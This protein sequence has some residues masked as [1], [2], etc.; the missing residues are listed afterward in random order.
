MND[1]RI[2]DQ[3]Q[4]ESLD[5]WLERGLSA[6]FDR[7]DGRAVPRQRSSVHEPPLPESIG[8]FEVGSVL[9]RGGTGVV[10]NVRDPELDRELAIKV[11]R[12]AYDAEPSLAGRFLTEARICARLQHPGIVPVHEIGALEDGR[13]WFAMRR[14]DGDTLADR[15]SESTDVLERLRLLDVFLQVCDTVAFAHARGVVHRDLKPS[16]VMLGEFGEVLVVDWGFAVDPDA[17][18]A[19]P[20]IIGTPS[21]MPPEQARG[22][23]VDSRADVFAL[24]AVLCEILTGEPPYVAETQSELLLSASRVWLSDAHHRLVGTGVDEALPKLARR[25]LSEDPDDRPSNAGE[26]ADAIREYLRASEQ[27]IRAREVQLAEERERLA[28]ERRARKLITGGSALIVIAVVTAFVAW[29][30]ARRESVARERDQEREVSSAIERAGVA[31]ARAEASG[32]DPVLWEA[33]RDAGSWLGGLLHGREVDDGLRRRAGELLR[34]VDE[35]FARASRDRRVTARLFE[36]RTHVGDHRSVGSRRAEYRAAFEAYGVDVG[37]GPIEDAAAIVNASAIR[38]GLLGALDEW[39]RLAA[40]ERAVE[41]AAGLA[42]LARLVDDDPWRNEVRLAESRLDRKSISD[43]ADRAELGELSAESLTL[44]AGALQNLGETGRAIDVYRRAHLAAPGD[45]WLNHDIGA[46]LRRRDPEAAARHFAMAVAAFPGDAHLLVDLAQML[47]VQGDERR[48]DDYLKRALALRPDDAAAWFYTATIQFR[49]G[50]LEE[51][52]VGIERT[53]AADPRF[54]A[55]YVRKA[56]LR[57]QKKDFEGALAILMDGH[58]RC[59]D[60]AEI[61]KHIGGVHEALGDQWLASHWLERSLEVNPRDPVAWLGLGNACMATLRERRAIVA[62]EAA[63]RLRPSY[64]EARCGLGNAYVLTGRIADGL[65]QLERGDREGRAAGPWRWPSRAWVQEARDAERR[66]A[67][68]ED[69]DVEVPD[70][71]REAAALGRVASVTG[72][73]RI[74]SDCF[75]YAFDALPSLAH[76][77]DLRLRAVTAEMAAATVASSE[78]AR[79]EHRLQAL[80]WLE[81]DLDAI[82][83]AADAP[84]A[85]RM[86]IR[87]VTEHW[88]ATEAL[89]PVRDPKRMS[90]LPKDERNRWT[91]LWERIREVRDSVAGS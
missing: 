62:Y 85:A 52:E 80:E 81:Q 56:S 59:G 2:M 8:R 82:P 55:A 86:V 68:L 34:Q 73:P 7:D 61:L 84:I 39:L 48:A 65:K 23:A 21:Y 49:R 87:S 14:I 31:L 89:A 18:L 6:A 50:N 43:I 53:L 32:G 26:V 4:G 64:P 45:A 16:N 12:H 40:R 20:Q 30:Q 69:D 57:V 38:S 35:R 22:E 10:L 13:P 44:L 25:C 76:V 75:R 79:E 54:A 3:P 42:G 83:L 33:A 24:G 27:R 51:A 11:L 91:E 74:A 15:L 17:D 46:V 77:A 63:L 29:N 67:V 5:D 36:I 72:H 60:D 66:A 47:L 19:A 70:D 28:A 37:D 9:G 58:S 78:A 1:D 71:P 41:E 88:L 90:Q